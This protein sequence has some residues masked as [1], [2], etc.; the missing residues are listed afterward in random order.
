M[1]SFLLGICSS[2]YDLWAKNFDRNT[3][4]Y[5]WDFLVHLSLSPKCSVCSCVSQSSLGLAGFP[6]K[7]PWK[8]TSYFGGHRWQDIPPWK[9]WSSQSSLGELGIT[10]GQEDLERAPM[11]GMA[12]HSFN[13]RTLGVRGQPGRQEQVFSGQTGQQRE[14]LS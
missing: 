10:K 14:T 13:P 1:K 8:Y 3:D 6:P 7:H 11:L 4:S 12:S 5:T 9:T 2:N